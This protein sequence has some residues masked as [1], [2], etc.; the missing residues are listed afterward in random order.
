MEKICSLCTKLKNIDSF[1][2]NKNNKD[3]LNSWCYEC[4]KKKASSY[5]RTKSGV[6]SKIYGHQKDNSVKRNH[7]PPCYSFNELRE[8]CYAQEIFHEIYDSWVL[9][10]FDSNLKPSIDRRDDYLPYSFENIRIIT[11]DE[12][13]KKANRDRVN[14]INNKNSLAILQFTLD[15]VFIAEYHSSKDAERKTDINHRHILNVCKKKP[16][17][18]TAGGYKWEYKKIQGNDMTK[19]QEA[20]KELKEN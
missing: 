8:W 20:L 13:N 10:N 7:I 4:Y 18:I 1:P 11:W 6:I 9:N 17:Y 16:K 5:S 19:E 12:N 14:G 15:N 3:G 2:R